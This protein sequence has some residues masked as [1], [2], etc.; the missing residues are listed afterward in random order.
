MPE[1]N[2]GLPL[3]SWTPP[4]QQLMH[5]HSTRPSPR[6]AG[7]CF[8]PYPFALPYRARE[9]GETH[10]ATSV[11]SIALEMQEAHFMQRGR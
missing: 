10:G 8:I 5:N 6:F 9:Y 1:L 2:H 11:L 7:L 4:L 3:E